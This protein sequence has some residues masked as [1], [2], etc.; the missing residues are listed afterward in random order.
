[1]S[2]AKKIAFC[3]VLMGLALALSYAERFIPLQLVIPLPG[4]KLGLANVVTLVALYRLKGRYAF[5]I[6][7]PRCILVAIFGGGITGLLTGASGHGILRAL[8]YAT[9]SA[10]SEMSR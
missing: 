1:M 8:S 3:A 9:V 2:K 4:I 5:A 6:V 7:I 10:P